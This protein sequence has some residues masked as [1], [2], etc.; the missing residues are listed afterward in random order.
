[1]LSIAAASYLQ[2]R[3]A[4]FVRSRTIARSTDTTACSD[5]ILATGIDLSPIGMHLGMYLSLHNDSAAKDACSSPMKSRGSSIEDRLFT[6]KYDPRNVQ[7][8]PKQAFPLATSSG[9]YSI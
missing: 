7:R 8:L 4:V 6:G 9:A 1:M 3:H 5:L 2:S